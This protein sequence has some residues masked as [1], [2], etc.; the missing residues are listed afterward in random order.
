MCVFL[1]ACDLCWIWWLLYFLPFSLSCPFPFSASVPHRH[2]SDNSFVARR[3]TFEIDDDCDSLTW[4]ENEETLLLWEDFA[5]YNM[6]C[7][8]S[9]ATC[10]T[11][12]HCDSSAEAADPVSAVSISSAGFSNFYKSE[13]LSFLWTLCKTST[14]AWWMRPMSVL[15]K[16]SQ[17]GSLGS[18]IDETESL[19]KTREQEYQE[20]IGQIEVDWSVC[21]FEVKRKYSACTLEDQSAWKQNTESRE[22]ASMLIIVC[23]VNEQLVCQSSTSVQTK[24]LWQ[25]FVWLQQFLSAQIHVLNL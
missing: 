4:E 21:E 25:L 6:P 19:F 5:N 16:D 13:C 12:G 1:F 3:E 7:A 8:I 14:H 22:Y 11:A 10:T 2:C 18:L 9:A 17:D 20:T 24:V 15:S 23:Y